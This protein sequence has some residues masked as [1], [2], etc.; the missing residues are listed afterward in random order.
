MN[1]TN[2]TGSAAWH[3]SLD[4]LADDSDTVVTL[5][6]WAARVAD[7][8][9]DTAEAERWAQIAAHGAGRLF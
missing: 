6:V 2:G 3:A 9:G 7:S 4:L 1:P 8:D 5:A